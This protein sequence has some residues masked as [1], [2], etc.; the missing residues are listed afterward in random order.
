MTTP[1]L[2]DRPRTCHM[3]EIHPDLVRIHAVN[4]AWMARLAA[5]NKDRYN[6]NKKQTVN[7][8]K[9]SVTPAAR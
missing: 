4:S 9:G 5:L 8:Y 2:P 1:I 6:H 7:R 3:T